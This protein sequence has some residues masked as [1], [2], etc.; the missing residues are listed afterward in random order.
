MPN[1]NANVSM[2]LE[3]E[4]ITYSATVVATSI[5]MLFI[6]VY[7]SAIVSKKVIPKYYEEM[8]E[9][10]KWTW[11]ISFASIISALIIGPSA[12]YILLTEDLRSDM[13]WYDSH[14]TRLLSSFVIGYMISDMLLLV[15]CDTQKMKT[16]YYWHHVAAII[17]CGM[18]VVNK[19]YAFHTCLRMFND[20]STPFMHTRWA[21]LTWEEKDSPAY[22]ITVSFSRYYFSSVGLPLFRSAI[23]QY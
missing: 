11:K 20:I 6:G 16:Q 18:V 19:V 10:D 3:T 17:G 2:L 1:F 15:Y 22:I 8:S 14:A 4:I 21:L 23:A 12:T 7:V 5:L 9:E 13:F